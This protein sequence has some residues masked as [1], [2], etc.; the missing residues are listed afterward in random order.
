MEKTEN[1][2][3]YLE[4]AEQW[5]LA[6]ELSIEK[7]PGPAAFNALHSLELAVKGSLLAKTGE[8]YKTHNIGGEFGKFFYE[9]V[10]KE[11][12][13]ELNKKIMKYDSLRYPGVSLSKREAKEI[14]KF[15]KEFIEEI[16]PRIIK[17]I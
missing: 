13:R 2:S 14:L 10:G 16:I 8:E 11:K 7:A 5:L 9:K 15:A 12:C 6:A 3:E 17:E 4:K 1:I